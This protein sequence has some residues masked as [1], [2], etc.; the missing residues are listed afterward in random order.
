MLFRPQELLESSLV[1]GWF[2]VWAALCSSCLPGPNLQPQV[3]MFSTPSGASLGVFCV[4]WLAL[5]VI[6]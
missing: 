5:V 3:C 1:L 2:S 6:A 4:V